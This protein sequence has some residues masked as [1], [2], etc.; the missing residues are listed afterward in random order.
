MTCSISF[1]SGIPF[2]GPII[3]I[4]AGSLTIAAKAKPN[5]C[6]VKGSLALSIITSVF[7]IIGLIL[8][9]VD[10]HIIKFLY[11]HRN[12]GPVGG[13]IMDSVLLV[14]NLLLFC[15]SVSVAVF[16]CRSLN[17]AS[18]IVPQVF[19]IQNDVVI[20]MPPSVFSASAPQYA[21]LQPPPPPPPPPPPY[22]VQEQEKARPMD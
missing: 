21:E 10:L 3:Y 17:H 7:T 13:Y 8:A 2:W 11:H 12:A 6:L 20:S 1:P 18:S 14:T 9:C 5:I 19:V 15:S 4:I 16:G 22:M